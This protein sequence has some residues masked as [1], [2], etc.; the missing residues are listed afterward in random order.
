M[1]VIIAKGAGAHRE[2]LRQAV[3]SIGLEC[4]AQDCV[5][6]RELS[7]RLLQ[8]PAD[9]VLVG[10]G[11]SPEAALPVIRQAVAQTHSPV[12][13]MGRFADAEQI[14]QML[15]CGAR[16]YLREEDLAEE[17]LTALNKLQEVGGSAPTTW[18]EILAVVGAKPGVGVTTV[19]CNLAFAL[20]G[21]YP[22]RVVLAEMGAGVPELALDLDLQPPHSPDELVVHGDRLDAT[23]LRQALFV[24]P[25]GLNVLA[26]PGG[27]LHTPGVES[28]A[29]RQIALLL[30]T[31]FDLVILDLGHGI[32]TARR[33]ALCRAHQVIVPFNL[34]I[35]C[36]RLTRQLLRELEEGG[37]SRDQIHVVANRYGQRKQFN[38]KQAD[39]A[40][41]MPVQEWIPEDPG[42]ANEALNKGQPLILVEKHSGI[43][44]T[45]RK[46][47]TELTGQGHAK[48]LAG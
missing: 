47:A 2:Q 11:S 8:A 17:L 32:D 43:A 20:A 39:E 45:L 40:L 34:D 4:A 25:A 37:S 33:E 15:R 29:A 31:M 24:H 6:H 42:A 14:L 38:W 19:A 23:L 35:P 48:G 10:L 22:G 46:L 41:G 18:G 7:G 44:R 27:T 13:A 5:D 12:F 3:L 30:R 9:L 16:E 1:R 26:Y 21:S 28:P 36:M